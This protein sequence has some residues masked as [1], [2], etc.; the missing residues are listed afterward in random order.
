[1]TDA[2]VNNQ[3]EAGI[4]ATLVRHPEFIL[5]SDYLKPSYFYNRDNACIYWAIQEL[6]KAGID[7]IDA[8]NITTRIESNPKVKKEF[9]KYNLPDM[10]EY[11]DMS[12]AISRETLNEYLDLV[13]RVIELSFKRDLNR[14]LEEYQKICY[15]DI[16]LSELSQKVYSGLDSLTEKYITSN[17]IKIFGEVSDNLYQEICDRRDLSG[18]YGIPSKFKIVSDYFTYE[19]T[20][21]VLVSARMKKG[22]SALLMNEAMDK[23]QKGIPTLYIDT[24]MSDRLFF[25]R[26]LANLTGIEVKRVKNG[27]LSDNEKIN[28]EKAKV[29]IK[30]QPFVHIYDPSMT[31]EAVYSIC[32]ILK[33]K[34]GL[35]FVIWD[36][37]KS[38][39]TDSSLQYNELGSKCDFLKNEIAGELELAVLAAAQLNRQNQVAD[40]D[41]LER[42][43]SVSCKWEDKTAEEYLRD[44]AECGNYKLIIKLNRLG[45]QM[46]EDEYIDMMFDGNRMRIEQAKQQHKQAKPF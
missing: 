25:E 28:I 19:P 44:G 31:N 24:E 30:K 14:K 35:R 13:S 3:A 32:K 16:G 5:H 34:I 23:L 17:N 29:W 42:Y 33:Y 39:E 40:S 43:C 6:Y 9:E 21:L 18:T 41:K 2:I 8:F 26:V 4:V 36:Y 46:T 7:N 11:I 38:N 37:I 1:M 22:K 45:E 27:Q 10:Q 15:S 12:G 20:E